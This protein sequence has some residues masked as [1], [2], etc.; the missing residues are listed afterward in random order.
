MIK[1]I[2]MTMIFAA[3]AMAAH[4]SLISQA[5]LGQLSAGGAEWT[6]LKQYCDDNLNL[7]IGPD[8]AGWGWRTAAENYGTAYQVLRVSDP[9]TADKYAA[10][11][12]AVMKV[13]ARHHNYGGPANAQL[14]GQGDGTNRVF[15]LPMTPLAG[16]SVAVLT[17]PVQETTLVYSGTTVVLSHFDPIVKISNTPGGAAGYAAADY[18]L[19]YRDGSTIYALKWLTAN[20]PSN[21]A[22]Y[23]VSMTTG[24]GTVMAAGQYTVSGTTLTLTAAPTAAQAVYVRY[25]ADNYDQTGNFLGGMPSVTPDGPGYQMRTFSPGLAFGFDLLYD[26]AGFTAPLKAEFADVLNQQI[27]WYKSYGYER[28]GDLGNYFIR[29][30]LTGTL[31]TAW[32]T[33]GANSRTAELKTLADGYVQRPFTKLDVKLPGGFG[34]QGQYANGVATDVLQVFTIYKDLTGQDLLSQLEWTSNIIPATIHGTKPDRATFYDGGDWSDLPAVPL[35]GLV[36]SFLTY[37]PGH[38]MAPYARQLLTDLGETVPSG[39]V[40]DYKTVFPPA[41][42]AKVSGPV[43][44]RTDWS[45]GAVWV[46][47][48]AEEVF[49]DHQGLDQG[50]L[51]IQRGADYLLCD[52]GGYGDLST[53]F[54]NT[55]LFDDRGAGNLSTYPPG[56]GYWGFDRVGIRAFEQAPS[57]V[58]GLADFTQS[59]AQ[60]HEGTQNSVK[61]AVR[62]MVF[63]RPDIVVVHDRAQTFNTAVKKYFNCNFSATPAVAGNLATAVLGQSKLFMRTLVPAGTVP[64]IIPIT[65]QAIAKSNYQ[66]M[67]TGQANSSFLHVFEATASTQAAM[68]PVSLVSAT[69]AEGAE[70]TLGSKAWIALFAATDSVLPG[71][72]TYAYTV[73]LPHQDIVADVQRNIIY[74]VSVTSGGQRVYTDS[75]VNSS[76]NG[77]LS[78]DYP[79]SDTGHVTFVSTGAPA[80]ERA[81]LPILSD[82]VAVQAYSANVLVRVRLAHAQPL[83]IKLYDIAGKITAD[84]S[85]TRMAAGDHSVRLS[86]G[87]PLASGIYVVRAQFDGKA[88]SRTCAVVH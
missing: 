74:K 18:K 7:I 58:Y 88:Q 13:L 16:T 69:G 9:A 14:L 1:I 19:F 49:M 87:A 85:F 72:V 41:Y 28:D 52:G 45:T 53:T 51:T 43:Y 79:G 23:Y 27:D 48:A 30:L 42:F 8:Y 6:A 59:Y 80:V 35:T 31:F 57:Y 78:I 29:G 24:S 76:L 77:T 54:H 36:N 71:S 44:A 50:N 55:L 10:K 17:T 37:L 21:S 62:S 63:I 73:K 11:C 67:V 22:S 15:T 46:S 4:P 32:G 26:Y 60:A 81:A 39:S 82:L 5:R 3:A 61:A 20:H 33:E 83:T 12:L 34:P 84:R 68:Q 47:L 40:A 2:A 65:G 64:V 66:E 25:I 56:Q 70:I 86:P 38:P 75:L